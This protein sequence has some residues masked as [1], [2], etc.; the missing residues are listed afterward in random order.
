MDQKNNIVE[1]GK[2]IKLSRGKC[3]LRGFDF[4]KKLGLSQ[5]QLSRYENGKNS[6]DVTMLTK[7][8][9]LLDVNLDWL[10]TGE[11]KDQAEDEC[12]ECRFFEQQQETDGFLGLCLRYP[13]VRVDHADE[14]LWPNVYKEWW[15]GEFVKSSLKK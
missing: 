13:P 14:G 5:S 11:E 9:E 1:F 12:G 8:A 15:C 4:A 2:R 6:P 7:I 3:G 10:I